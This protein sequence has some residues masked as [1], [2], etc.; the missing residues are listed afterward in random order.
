MRAEKKTL[1]NVLS[2]TQRVKHLLPRE[3]KVYIFSEGACGTS[4]QEEATY[5]N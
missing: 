1:S 3:K 4:K 5:V 2:S